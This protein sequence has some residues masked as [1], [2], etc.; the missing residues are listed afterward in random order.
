MNLLA[1]DSASSI[2]SIAIFANDKFYVD[3]KDARTSHSEYVMDMIDQLVK[4]AR[5]NARKLDGIV[6]MGGPG[7]FSG[8][9]IGFSAAKGLSLALGIPFA[10]I[11]SLDCIAAPFS[12]TDFVIPVI[13]AHKNAYFFAL[14]RQGKIES[15]VYD[16]EIKNINEL[17][18]NDTFNVKDIVLTGP[19][20]DTLYQSVS[21]K[22][23]NRISLAFTKKGYS[24]E[25][26]EIANKNKLFD[27]INKAWY[28]QG[29]DYFRKTDAEKQLAINTGA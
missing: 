9:R 4:K 25:L 7:S 13:P 28:Y 26:I 21:L 23:Q 10:P 20:S 16:E 6:C 1:I 8:L 19:G 15:P 12:N 22:A 2:L 29:P 27:N 3:E 17:F 18:E 11:L 5:V 14:Y 24:K